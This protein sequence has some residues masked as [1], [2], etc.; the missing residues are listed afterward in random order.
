LREYYPH[1]GGV[2]N[3]LFQEAFSVAHEQELKA[4]LNEFGRMIKHVNMIRHELAA[5]RSPGPEGGD[6]FETMNEQVAAAVETTEEASNSIMSAM[7]Q[8]GG[9]IA[10]LQ[11]RE[12]DQD[13]TTTLQQMAEVTTGVYE[14]CA[15]QDLT[16]QRLARVLKLL[17]AVE[18]RVST[19]VSIWGAAEI[20]QLIDRLESRTP[21]EDE[22][23]SGPQRKGAGTSQEEID[24]L[25]A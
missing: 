20:Q 22:P 16:S 7:D 2:I 15:F 1:P 23:L 5:L 8:L 11:G 24:R 3:L 4:L 21:R 9:M 25:F 18:T 19:I 17:S 12:L 6:A 13:T 10:E 14:A